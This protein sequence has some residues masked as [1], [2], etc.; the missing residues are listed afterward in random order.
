M[1]HAHSTSRHNGRAGNGN[2][3][4]PPLPSRFSRFRSRLRLRRHRGRDR[5]G[6]AG[7]ASESGKGVA[8]DEF[9][10]IARIRIV[11]VRALP[12]PLRQLAV[13]LQFCVA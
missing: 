5:C 2:G 10:G 7:D 9:A 8:A 12:S 11:K 4:E 6:A 3:V 1:G 13:P